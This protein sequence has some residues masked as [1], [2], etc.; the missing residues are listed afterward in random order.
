MQPQGDLFRSERN[1]EFN[2]GGLNTD[3]TLLGAGPLVRCNIGIAAHGLFDA[4]PI[5]ASTPITTSRATATTSA[6]GIAP[7]GFHYGKV[8]YAVGLGDRAMRRVSEGTSNAPFVRFP[9]VGRRFRR[10]DNVVANVTNERMK[11][12]LFS[13]Q[14][15]ARVAKEAVSGCLQNCWPCSQARRGLPMLAPSYPNEA[16]VMRN[17]I[18]TTPNTAEQSFTR[19]GGG[20]VRP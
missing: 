10:I 15:L 18:D 6:G 12:S 3:R 20:C 7:P 5:C 13:K 4:R 17:R 8:R 19:S 14:A 16:S 1:S 2:L 11:A 9:A